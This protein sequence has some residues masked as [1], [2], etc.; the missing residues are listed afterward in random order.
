MGTYVLKPERGR[1][2]YVGWSSIVD[3]ATW[4]GPRDYA[5]KMLGRDVP[6]GYDPK[7]GN[8]PEDRLARADE[9]GTSA[10]WPET[11]GYY[12]GWDDRAL[13]VEQRGMLPRGDLARFVE[14]LDVCNEEAAYALVQPFEDG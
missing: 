4:I 6:D 10:L 3:N 5:L 7:P 11:G 2:L 9:N 1:D 8:S 13:K 14:A 12:G